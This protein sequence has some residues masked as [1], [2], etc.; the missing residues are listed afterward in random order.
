MTSQRLSH[1]TQF[2]SGSAWFESGRRILRAQTHTSR[3]SVVCPF[4]LHLDHSSSRVW[5]AL[6]VSE[7]RLRLAEE[8]AKEAES[9]QQA[10]HQISAS[11]FIHMG[12]ELEDQQ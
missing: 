2:S 6:K 12:L 7:I 3:T 11:V 4:L 10:P 1:R 8:E 5:A 9:G